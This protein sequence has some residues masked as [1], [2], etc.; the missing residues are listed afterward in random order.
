MRSPK[1]TFPTSERTH[2]KGQFEEEP[3]EGQTFMSG[4]E[5]EHGG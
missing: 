3:D 5:A 4:S 1:A 2:D